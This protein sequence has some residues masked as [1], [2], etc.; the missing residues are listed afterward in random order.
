MERLKPRTL[1]EWLIQHSDSTVE[2][3]CAAYEQCAREHGERATLSV[4]QLNRWM[5]GDVQAARPVARRVAQLM[6]GYAFS[7]L[8]GHSDAQPQPSPRRNSPHRTESHQPGPQPK[9]LPS[10][11]GVPVLAQIPGATRPVL[12]EKAAVSP[13]LEE[14]IAMAAE[15][16]ARFTRRAGTSISAE[17]IDQLDA[18]VRWLAEDY[19]RTPPYAMFRPLAALRREVFETIERHPRPVLLP[20][21]Y[22]VAAQLSALLAHASSDLGQPYSA[23]SH[24][25]TAWLCADLAGLDSIRPYVRWVQ[26]NVAYWRGDFHDAAEL[27]VTGQRYSTTASDQARLHSQ[28]ARALAALKDLAG[29]D[30]ALGA[31]T[32]ARDHADSAT[33]DGVFNFSPGKAAYYASEVRASLG[34]S[35]SLLR[36]VADAEESIALFA[37]MPEPE[38]S[39]EL[40]AAARLDLVGAHLLLG[41]LDAADSHVAPVFDLHS[42]SRTVPIVSRVTKAGRTL[43]SDRF[44]ASATAA[45]LGERL[46]LFAAYPAARELP[47]LPT[48]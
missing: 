12:D 23:D 45:D 5:A 9:W 33:P 43:S 31:A 47:E 20:D 22:R 6:W 32:L 18:D 1:L 29:A 25:R 24:A 19:L 30:R 41:D 42:D 40:L 27:A 2:E 7:D 37:S 35:A 38:Q 46:S 36:A 21:L 15:E 4:R 10:G 8:V 11:P 28:H 13:P 3:H 39:P 48:G 44:S 26:S 14:E 34:G 16:S 17:A